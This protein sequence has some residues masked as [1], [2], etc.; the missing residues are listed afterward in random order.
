MM[1]AV[2]SN[3]NKFIRITLERMGIEMAVEEAWVCI[4][5]ETIRLVVRYGTWVIFEIGRFALG[6][7]EI[8]FLMDYSDLYP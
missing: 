1:A 2:R 3:L 5:N 6:V 8:G 4:F 7:V